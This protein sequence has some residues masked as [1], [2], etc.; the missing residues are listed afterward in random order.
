[1][2][3]LV[4]L[5]TL[6]AAGGWWLWGKVTAADVNS[7]SEASATTTPADAEAEVEA[8]YRAYIAM[9]ERVEAAPDPDDPEISERATGRTL[10]RL[11]Q[12]MADYA[13][14][15]QAVHV[16]AAT[17]QTILSIDVSGDRATVRVCFVD[18][19]GVFDVA[20]GAEIVPVH[21]GT[22]IDTTE[23]ERTAGAWRVSSRRPPA[24]DEQW[25]GVTTCD[26]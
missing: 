12:A 25:E 18:E 9:Q 8:A 13:A 22:S 2:V 14:R 11:R 21:T 23:L 1:M 16:G 17:K 19:S 6:L 24:A 4:V 26:Q 15:G 5:F 10:D 3:A 7:R 20:T